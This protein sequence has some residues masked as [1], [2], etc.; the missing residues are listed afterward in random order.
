MAE[1]TS[2]DELEI[3]SQDTDRIHTFRKFSGLGQ[4]VLEGPHPET[5]EKLIKEPK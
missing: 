1:N 3:S 2:N 5:N 4:N